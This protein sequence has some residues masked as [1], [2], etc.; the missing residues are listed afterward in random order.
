[1]TTVRNAN[2]K[3]PRSGAFCLFVDLGIV[4]GF[5]VSG[6]KVVLFFFAEQIGERALLDRKPVDREAAKA[7]Q[8]A[9]GNAADHDDPGCYAKARNGRYFRVTADRA[10]SL[11]LAVFQ[12]RKR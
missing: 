9:Y 10:A 6:L 1:M 4:C 7:Q 8:K 2:K 12:D 11:L 3:S 5:L